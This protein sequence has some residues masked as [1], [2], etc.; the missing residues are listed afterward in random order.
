MNR[1][2]KI[3]GTLLLTVFLFFMSAPGIFAQT[4]QVQL[5]GSSIPQFIDPLPTLM[6]STVWGT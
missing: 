2:K 1:T 3:Q 4:T 5:P 6:G